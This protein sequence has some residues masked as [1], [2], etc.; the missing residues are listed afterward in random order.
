MKVLSEKSEKFTLSVK[1]AQILS[2]YIKDI[3]KPVSKIAKT[4]QLS[5]HSVEY[6]IKQMHEL[7]IITGHKTIINIR[8]LGYTS[9]HVFLCLANNDQEK[10]LLE[11]AIHA[12]YVNAVITYRGKYTFEISIIARS[13][14]EFQ[15]NYEEL[16]KGIKLYQEETLILTGNIKSVVIPENFL[17]NKKT[18]TQIP[19]KKTTPTKKYHIDTT[20]LCLLYEI[21]NNADKSNTE[22]ATSLHISKDTIKYRL[23]K[24]ESN[25]YIIQYRPAINYY[26]LGFSIHSLLL[27]VD[28]DANVMTAFEKHIRGEDKIIW[29]TKC[30]GTFNYVVYVLTE[31]VSGFH[32]LF[33]K[34][35]T[36]FSSFINSYELLFAHHEYKYSFFANNISLEQKN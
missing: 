19:L 20:D 7:G 12:D 14:E 23:Q 9:Y 34:L 5:R 36:E 6:K 1:D 18:L 25:N 24:L 28:Y 10:E 16:I 33:E 27:K 29:A 4:C 13:I 8:K 22:L 31:D 21:A 2:E 35:K 11:R 30:F 17:Q 32:D 26:S 3:R 15:S